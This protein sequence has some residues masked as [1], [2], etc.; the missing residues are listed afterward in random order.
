MHY[1]QIRTLARKLRNNATPE[2][3]KLWTYLRK[4]Q[5][6]GAR[7]NRQFPIVYDKDESDWKFYIADFYCH[8]HKLCVELDGI[9]HD[10]TKERDRYRDMVINAVGISVLRIKN[11]ELADM[12]K[13]LDKIREYL[14]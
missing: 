3:R 12:E 5:L 14:I 10:L 1:L 8:E 11:E 6:E 4:R 7:F 9:I 2:E 13:V